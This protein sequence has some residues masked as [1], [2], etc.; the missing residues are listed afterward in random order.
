MSI[1][2]TIFNYDFEFAPGE[3][4]MRFRNEEHWNLIVKQARLD[5]VFTRRGQV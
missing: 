5:C 4:G 1:A 3:D 2:Y